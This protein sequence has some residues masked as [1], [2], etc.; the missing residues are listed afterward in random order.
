MKRLTIIWTLALMS[1]INSFAQP[2]PVNGEILADTNNLTVLKVWGTHSERGYAHGYL[3]GD[4][5]TD[6]VQGYL[7]PY[8][9]S[10][11]QVARDLVSNGE[12][13]IIDS[14]YQVEA[15]S[16]VDGMNDAGLNTANL[17]Y[18][19]ILVGSCWSDLEGYF[20]KSG[21][22][23]DCSCLLN[24]GQGSANSPLNGKSIAA[25]FYDWGGYQQTIINNAV[26]IAHVPSEPGLQPWLLVGY[27]GEMV[28]TGGGVSQGGLS[29]YK[30]GMGDF[31]CSAVPG[32]AYVPY[33]F[34]MR[35]I[36]ETN[37]FNG[38]GVHNTQDARDGF[39]ANPQGYPIDKIIPVIARNDPDS[40]SLTAMIIEIASV[41][42]T[43]TYRTNSYEDII[44]GDNLYAA[45]S[46]IKRNNANNYCYRYLNVSNHFGDSTNIGIERNDEIMT[47]YSVQP[48]ARNYGYIQH[49]PELDLLKV[50]VIRDGIDAYALPMTDFN[51]MDF[52]NR[53][54]DFITEAL[55]EIEV[56]VEYVYEIEVTDP[57]PYDTISIVSGQLP[58]WLTLEDL[59]NGTALLSGTPDQAGTYQVILK[60]CDGFEEV[61]QE[62][63]IEVIE[64][65]SCLPEG[66][67]FSTQAKIDSF[68][69]NYPGCNEIEGSV[70]IGGDDIT[71]LDSLNCLVSINGNL[72][73]GFTDDPYTHN[74]NLTS[75]EGLLNLTSVGG[76]LLISRNDILAN[77]NGLGGIAY[78]GGDLHITNN[79][80]LSNLDGLMGI[81]NI[82]GELE[83][84][85]NHSLI[86][87]LGLDNLTSIGNH[88]IIRGNDYIDNLT[89]LE[90]LTGVGGAITIRY[91]QN[92]SSLAGLENL[93]SFGGELWIGNNNSLLSI[94]ALASLANITDITIINNP[95]LSTCD[96]QSICNYLV[97]PNGIVNIYNNASGCNSPEEIA[98]ECGFIMPCLPNGNYHFNSQA[99][100]DNFQV[101]YPGCTELEGDV[102]IHGADISSLYGLSDVI[103]ISGSLTI[104][105][106]SA[107]VMGVNHLL[108]NLAGLE[109][110]SYI[111]GDLVIGHGTFVVNPALNN[112]AGLENLNSIGGYLS[113]RSND[114]LMSLNGLEG[115]TAVE[116]G[117]I[118]G[119]NYKIENLSGLNSLSFI[120]FGLY[121]LD[122]KSLKDLTG[123]ESLTAINANLRIA[124]NDS[125]TSLNGL[126]NLELV[127]GS[128]EIGVYSSFW[129]GSI[130]GNSQLKDMSALSNL[131][132]IGEN[133][134]VIGCDSLSKLTGLE[135]LA[136]IPGHLTIG[137]SDIEGTSGANRSLINLEGLNG[138]DS[139]GGGL[140][141]A[142][143]H[144]LSELS[145]LEGLTKVG[146]GLFIDG[147]NALPG[148]AGL[149]N[150]QP[151]S[152][153]ELW[154]K[155]NT[156]LSACE[157]QSICDY[158]ALPNATVSISNN[159]PGCNSPE[160][161]Q[162][163][164]DT[165]TGVEMTN[166]IL[167]LKIYPSPVNEFATLQFHLDQPCNGLIEIFNA[168]GVRVQSRQLQF[169]QAGQQHLV[170]DC[171]ALSC[172]IYF[173]RVRIENEVVTGKIIKH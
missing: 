87:L 149:D 134:N 24:W 35:K 128:V 9:G 32:T 161:V 57:D 120:G 126:D 77:L 30:N 157:V 132:T 113:I 140:T 13:L 49:I 60:A 27:A 40:D 92:L 52:F 107:G 10:S 114:S 84:R 168:T 89:G 19:D 67:Y 46:Q 34:T 94:E 61:I 152:I 172:G 115:L 159:A 145:A 79:P 170:L 105:Y 154:I 68:Q 65:S 44:P 29:M 103:G 95:M 38:D 108:S 121:I 23:G 167:E 72:E 129:M 93:S 102:Y 158:L 151:F 36:L 122:S 75:L 82:A 173:C 81:S 90:N 86:N 8:F 18:I 58:E 160:E 4:K 137:M 96:G 22:G 164:C 3:I 127:A 165:I 148:L 55:L 162:A 98:A 88:L 26:L 153:Q 85:D 41:E 73:I 119:G 51:L 42:P 136:Y 17:D 150:I 59:G 1:A 104:G 156:L 56:G 141:I 64:F 12:D 45:N 54:P 118:V 69:M 25:R 28:P 43:H 135:N 50:S 125:L 110:L 33:I 163:A 147:N 146:G 117:V 124:G 71:N 11:Y 99:D 14:L 7:I 139:I 39:D 169:D 76:N 133:L 166:K 16:M 101:N 74:P 116:G 62:Y 155:D 97:A 47:K 143:N 111:G 83:I 21:S 31:Y 48:G 106:P 131:S 100:L 20:N 171:T 66:I 70:L 53:P 5:I 6:I 78:L 80:L 130:S 63:N 91:N 142:N 123:L 109:S 2:N 138:I 112:L 15:M 37:D 144:I